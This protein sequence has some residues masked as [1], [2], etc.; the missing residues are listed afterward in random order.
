MTTTMTTTELPRSPVARVLW[1]PVNVLQAV[2]VASV[3]AV[4]VVIAMIVRLFSARAPL[5]MARYVWAPAMLGIGGVRLEITGREHLDSDAVQVFVSNHE[6][7]VDIPVVFRVLP[8][9]LRFILKRE[10]AF[11]PFLG[12]FAWATGMVFVDRRRR[13]KAITAL[14]AVRALGR[15]GGSIIAFP[16]GTRSRGRGILPFKKGVFISA[17]DAQIPVVPVA[18]AGAERVLP[19]SGFRVRPGTIR[20]AIGAPIPTTGLTL[21]DR[22]ALA[23]RARDAVIAL[24]ASIS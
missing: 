7:M 1:I 22:G 16:E 4:L 19:C 15:G 18:I 9:P 24:H 10:L 23:A 21:S 8:A 11:V 13:E 6:S 14:R 20:L 12:Q 2:G 5:M 3:T 17:I